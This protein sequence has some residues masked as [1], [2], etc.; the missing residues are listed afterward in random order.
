MKFSRRSALLAA[1]TAAALTL[2]ACG[3]TASGEPSASGSPDSAAVSIT[4][5]YGTTTFEQA[6]ER[7]ATISWVNA[8]TL[9]ALGTVPVGMDKDTWGNNDNGS[10]D[11]KDEKLEELGA[12]IGSENAPVQFDATDGINYTQIA[13]AK[14][15]AIFAAYSGLTKEEY[16]KLSK[17]AP[18]VGPIEPNY[19]TSWQDATEAAGKMLHKQDEAKTLVDSVNQQIADAASKYPIFKDTTFI[20][21]NLEPAAGGINIYATGDTR[22]RFLS[23]LGMTQAEVVDKNAKEGEFYYNFAA[24]RA[25]E[26]E[27]DI[28]FTWVPAGSTAQDVIAENKLFGQI[29][30]AKTGGFVALDS[31]MELLSI[32]AASAL[33][34]PW[35]LDKVV[36][37]LGDAANK[38]AEAKK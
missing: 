26:L 5:S 20:A 2:T 19:T 10:T 23:Q 17:I 34:L 8:D 25:S 32:S 37:R 3:G 18:V 13:E 38:V 16:D 28:F 9:L 36:P 35:V 1:A 30:A 33:S 4:H 22:P 12:G 11:W 15:D 6:P 7:V 29:P 31:D 27:A 24:E 21:G 14:P